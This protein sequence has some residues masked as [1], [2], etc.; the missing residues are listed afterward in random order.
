MKPQYCFST[1]CLLNVHIKYLPN[2]NFGTFSRVS[3]H[4][5]KIFK[6]G[7]VPEKLGRIATQIKFKVVNGVLPLLLY[8][9]SCSRGKCHM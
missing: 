3:G 4:R 9:H 6:I 1:K 2:F 5:D 8:T 7:I